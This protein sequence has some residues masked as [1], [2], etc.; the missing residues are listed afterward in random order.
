MVENEDGEMV[1]EHVQETDTIALYHSMRQLLVYLTHL[2]VK[3][4]E[5]ILTEKLGRQIDGSEWSWNNLNRLCWAIGS[6][7]GTM[8]T[9]SCWNFATLHGLYTD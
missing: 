8:G 7:S 6:I 1:R 2:G 3:E 4:T 9:H 5:N